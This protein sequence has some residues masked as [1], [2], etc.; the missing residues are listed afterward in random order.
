MSIEQEINDN[1]SI[2]KIQKNVIESII[3][4]ELS[5]LFINFE[6]NFNRKIFLIEEKLTKTFDEFE[7]KLNQLK[8]KHNF[9]S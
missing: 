3:Q 9:F 7:S 5:D 8:D 4:N 6:E 2:S 1:I